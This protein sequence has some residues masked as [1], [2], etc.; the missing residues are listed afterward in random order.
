VLTAAQV[1]RPGTPVFF[2]PVPS[3]LDMPT[4]ALTYASPEFLLFHM[5]NLDL[6]SHYGLPSYHPMAHTD[7]IELDY[8]A[9]MER[10]ISMFLLWSAGAPV[11]GGAGSYHK[12][13]IVSPEQLVLDAE[14]YRFVQ[15]FHQGL[16]LDED[17]LALDE[18]ERVG[19]SGNF[20]TEDRTLR[21]YRSG[22]H[23]LSGVLNRKMR[24]SKAKSA[25][26]LAH[27]RV[28]DLLA[29]HPPPTPEGPAEEI[30]RYM[31]DRLKSLELAQAA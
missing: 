25:L 5:A 6:T 30:R 28:R 27:G 10:G 26:E 22:L 12:T 1:V 9:G 7:A 18:I 14:F 24:A 29:N 16:A 31:R 23:F 20:L 2:G 8:Q 11:I 19:F 15:H 17:S 21:Y 13:N 4:G 3:N